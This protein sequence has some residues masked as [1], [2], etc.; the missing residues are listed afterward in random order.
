M[1]FVLFPE[2]FEL[3]V[4]ISFLFVST[5]VSAGI[6]ASFQLLGRRTSFRSRT[7]SGVRSSRFLPGL[8]FTLA[9]LGTAVG[10]LGGWS[11]VGVVGNV[12]PAILTLVGALTVYLFD[13]KNE[14][15][16]LVIVSTITFTICLFLGFVIGTQIR[17][18]S[19]KHTAY[20]DFCLTALSNSDLLNDTQGYCRF[21]AGPGDQCWSTLFDNTAAYKFPAISNTEKEE[22]WG[23]ILQQ[24]LTHERRECGARLLKQ[25][26]PVSAATPE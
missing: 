24:R 22:I 3:S 20:R 25:L 11:R 23:R 6:I 21:L 16:I 5:I 2:P 13:Q 9:L 7:I 8:I 18:P 14:K 10:I 17:N 26:E 19:E 1:S 12:V 15:T 4:V